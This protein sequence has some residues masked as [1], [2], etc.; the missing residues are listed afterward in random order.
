[1]T[2]T[3]DKKQIQVSRTSLGEGWHLNSLS[4]RIA[5]ITTPK[6]QRQTTYFGFNSQPEA[7]KFRNQLI[8]NGN[9]KEARLRQAERL[10]QYLWEVKAW[11][12][13][14]EF[15]VGLVNSPNSEFSL[16]HK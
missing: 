9:C 14:T 8:I 10:S 6:G 5:T 7:E 2:F 13:N 3:L 11:G 15:I 16:S 12:V 1:M 4:P